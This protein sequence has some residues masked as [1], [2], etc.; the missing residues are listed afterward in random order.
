MFGCGNRHYGYKVLWLILS[1]Q[2]HIMLID[3]LC[4][5]VWCLWENRTQN[6]E[7]FVIVDTAVSFCYGRHCSYL[8]GDIVYNMFSS[9]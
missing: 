9:V 3:I 2:F 4:T 8:F 5:S 1:F 7:D 6:A